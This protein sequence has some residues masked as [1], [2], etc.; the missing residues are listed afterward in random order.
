MQR[1]RTAGRRVLSVVT[2][3]ILLVTC[4]VA[5]LSVVGIATNKIRIVTVLTGSMT[6][7]IPIDTLVVA[8]PVTAQDVT[9]GQVIVFMPPA[10]FTTPG[11]RPMVHRVASIAT[12]KGVLEIR[13]KG[14]ANAA[15]DPW[16]LDANRTTLFTPVLESP[17][18]GKATGALGT[19]GLPA[20]G[21]LV[22]VV[23]CSTVLR[24]I[25]TATDDQ[26]PAPEAVTDTTERKMADANSRSAL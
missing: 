20:L 15:V 8:A 1:T 5:I 4:G 6:P 25:W 26:R 14:D 2:T 24:R 3:V 23:L 16:I 12:V 22:I 11:A 10:A 18:A 17:A 21:I 7:G 13:T 19:Y 9:V